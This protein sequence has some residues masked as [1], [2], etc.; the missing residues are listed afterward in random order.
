MNK[1]FIFLI[2]S[3]VSISGFA[4]IRSIQSPYILGDTLYI[5]GPIGS[6][7]YDYLAYEYKALRA[8]KKVSLNSYGGSHDWSLAVAEKI[9]ANKWDSV[10]TA[11]H[12]CAS[13]CVYLFGAGKNRVMSKT[14]WLGVHGARITGGYVITFKN[15]C[16]EA[17]LEK[18]EQLSVHCLTYL[19]KMHALALE[20][21]LKAFELM[22][23][24]GVQRQLRDYYFSLEDDPHWYKFNNI[25]RKPDLVLTA[26]EALN[27]NLATQIF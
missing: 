26:E 10:L 12:V 14:A 25:L 19:S 4:E 2:V 27:F 5:E 3:F 9:K 6:H 24:S 20:S 7:I 15:L 18:K 17:S 1:V 21:T 13:A 23:A 11:E 8:V 16:S 22:E